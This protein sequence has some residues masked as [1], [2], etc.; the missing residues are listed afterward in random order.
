MTPR[1]TS[2]PRGRR[3]AA[4][5]VA[6]S[7]LATLFPLLASAPA[8]AAACTDETH[9]T[10]VPLGATGCDDTT[11][12][13]TTI[14]LTD[15]TPTVLGYI[16]S[17]TV[18]FTF[19]GSYTAEDGTDAGPIGFE[20]QLYNTATPPAQWDACTSP[21]KY[22]NLVDDAAKAYTF[23]VRAVDTDDEAIAAC[24]DTYEVGDVLCADEEGV[25]DVDA[26]PANATFKVDTSPPNTFLD[27]Q[28][29]DHVTPDWPV[30]TSASPQLE[31]NS[32][33]SAGFACTLNGKSFTP[34]NK[35]IVT[36]A[37]L[38]GGDYT[39]VARAYDGAFNVDP[40]PVQTT[41]FVPSN[42]RKNKKSGWKKVR[43]AGLFGNDYLTSSKV[44]QTTTIPGIKNV[45]E[46]R[47]LAPTGPGYGKVE[48]RVG[49][50]QWYTVNLFSKKPRALAQL[51]VRD[52]YTTPRSGTIQIRVKQGTVRI[53][54]IVARGTCKT[55]G[56]V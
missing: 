24:D 33:E 2:R 27:G 53:D 17:T 11:P 34:C 45:R 5:L 56:D 16:R 26:S 31:L 20:C 32:N 1:L 13:D 43:Q 44:G 30:V 10:S 55:C 8:Q 35:G 25:D 9:N 47:L 19:T 7:M 18:T 48:V 14:T 21:K 29:V 51:L 50:S 41:F 3:H 40:T 23:R 12:P 39:F 54:A 22:E 4:A 28:P 52:E 46:V 38:R 42:I 36:L 15:P 49:T 37:N 6:T